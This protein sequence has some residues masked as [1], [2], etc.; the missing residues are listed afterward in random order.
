MKQMTEESGSLNQKLANFLLIYRKTPQA[1]TIE[2][3]AMLLMKRLP[4]SKI[5]FITPDLLKK[6]TEKQDSQKKV[7]T[8]TPSQKHF[9]PRR[10]C[11]YIEEVVTRSN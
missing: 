5:D 3:P 9:Q 7:L 6:V 10:H 4:R 11:G 8:K 2:S 1:T